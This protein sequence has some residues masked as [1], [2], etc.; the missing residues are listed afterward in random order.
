MDAMDALVTATGEALVDE[1]RPI[2]AALREGRQAA[3]LEAEELRRQVDRLRD[4]VGALTTA[5]GRQRMVTAE[6]K[7]E[8]L[9]SRAEA[10]AWRDTVEN[11]LAGC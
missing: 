4:R 2:E 8:A 7:A 3:V 9:R 11:S 10:D 1:P 6:A 5:L